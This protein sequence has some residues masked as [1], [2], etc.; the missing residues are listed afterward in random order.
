MDPCGTPVPMPKVD[1]VIG[2]CLSEK[3][4]QKL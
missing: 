4:E 1:D 2:G 3:S